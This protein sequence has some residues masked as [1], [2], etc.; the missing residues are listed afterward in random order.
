M[1]NGRVWILKK[2][3]HQYQDLHVKSCYWLYV[4][5]ETQQG[6]KLNSC[7]ICQ[8]WMREEVYV[9]QL[10]GFIVKNIDVYKLKRHCTISNEHHELGTYLDKSIKHFKFTKLVC[11]RTCCIHKRKKTS[12]CHCWCIV[13]DLILIGK[14]PEN[15]NIFKQQMMSDFKKSKHGLLMFYLETEVAQQEAKIIHNQS[16]Y[17]K[18]VLAQFNMVEC[19]ATN[20]LMEL[21]AHL[22]KDPNGEHMDAMEY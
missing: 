5:L 1:Y 8:S 2:F 6:S 3:L 20:I 22:H 9:T 19:N 16:V 7:Y 10:D 11:T 21:K 18:K 13:D 15:I 12:K 4:L 14:G 17:S